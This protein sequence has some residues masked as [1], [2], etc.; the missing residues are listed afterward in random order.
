MVWVGAVAGCP[1]GHPDCQRR[2]P[3]V[4]VLM[5]AAWPVVGMCASP[6]PCSCA[7]R[8]VSALVLRSR[9]VRR[10]TWRPRRADSVVSGPHGAIGAV[11]LWRRWVCVV[12]KSEPPTR[13]QLPPRTFT[14]TTLPNSPFSH[15]TQPLA[16]PLI[17]T[18]ATANLVRER[19]STRQDTCICAPIGRDPVPRPQ[20]QH[21]AEPRTCVKLTLMWRY[22]SPG[23]HPLMASRGRSGRLHSLDGCICVGTPRGCQHPRVNCASSIDAALAMIGRHKCESHQRCGWV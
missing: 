15:S 14:S 3:A 21:S 13:T 12:R 23:G 20:R 1:Q 8:R 10:L 17:L 22:S 7:L 18:A 5:R 9:R 6:Q 11:V 16:P 4:R 2:V 19:T